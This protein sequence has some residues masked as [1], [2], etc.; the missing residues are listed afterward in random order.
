MVAAH[1]RLAGHRVVG[2]GND[3]VEIGRPEDG[4]GSRMFHRCSMAPATCQVR[5]G[6]GA[7]VQRQMFRDQGGPRRRRRVHGTVAEQRQVFAIDDVHGEDP[8]EGQQSGDSVVR[9]GPRMSIQEYAVD[10]D[11]LTGIVIAEVVRQ[12][13][14]RGVAGASVGRAGIQFVEAFDRTDQ[15]LAGQ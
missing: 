3:Y 8:T 1:D 14:P 11:H 6:P 2:D 4:D 5:P 10:P 9:R 12:G 13:H 7:S 15:H